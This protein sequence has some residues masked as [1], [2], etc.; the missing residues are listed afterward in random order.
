M[1]LKWVLIFRVETEFIVSVVNAQMFNNKKAK[2][3]VLS[4]F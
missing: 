4:V 2:Y 1:G 3:S